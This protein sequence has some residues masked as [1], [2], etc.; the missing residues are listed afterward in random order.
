MHPIS[1]GCGADWAVSG[2]FLTLV[3][4]QGIL[5]FLQRD[6]SDAGHEFSWAP[7]AFASVESLHMRQFVQE[8]SCT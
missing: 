7:E 3:P 4:P 1:I 5:C 2:T 6:V 8:N